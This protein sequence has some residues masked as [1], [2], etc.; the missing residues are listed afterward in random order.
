MS[1]QFTWT[2]AL[3]VVAV[4][5]VCLVARPEQEV[6]VRAPGL[7]APHVAPDASTPTGTGL[8]LGR[9]VDAASGRPIPAATVTLASGPTPALGPNQ[10]APPSAMTNGAGYFL[11]RD[12]AK[13]S[14]PITATAQG[15]VGGA[16][17][18]LQPD[19]PS[20]PVTLGNDTRA[21]DVVI[22]MWKHGVISGAVR[23]ERGDPM[24]GV[25]VRVLRRTAGGRLA[26]ALQTQTDDRGTY[27]IANL[28]PGD[29]YVAML[30]NTGSV[31]A[32]LAA[33]MRQPGSQ[34]A[35]DLRR[36]LPPIVGAITFG[37]ESI[38]VGDAMISTLGP[39]G[40][41]N[42]APHVGPEGRLTGFRST[43]H[44]AAATFAEAEVVRIGSGEERS[45]VDINVRLTPML[46]IS[47]T[48]VGPDG[49]AANIGVMLMA[50]ALDSVAT[51]PGLETSVTVTGADGRFT[52][53]GVGPGQ[54]RLKAVRVPRP[55][56]P[57]MSNTTIINVGPGAMIGFGGGPPEPPPVSELPTLWADIPITVGE[58]DLTG[59]TLTL[60]TGS[61]IHGQV[62]FEGGA[63][64]S[65]AEMPRIG[66][67]LLLADDRV[68][69]LPPPA[70]VNQS[71]RQ[72]MTAQYPAGRY[73]VT[74]ISLPT[75]WSVRSAMADGV[76]VFERP[77]TLSGQDVNGIVIALTKQP[78]TL[79]GQVRRGTAA[80]DP[81]AIVA[82]FPAD[83]RSW[84]DDGMS[85]RRFRSGT[86]QPDGTFELSG[87]GAGEYIV[88]A[89]SADQPIDGRN[90][91]TI[92]ALARV[93]TR[94][95]I[96]DGASQ[97]PPLTVTT[98]R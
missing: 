27:R 31:P 53:L 38:R 41:R 84:I 30:T 75:G 60:A 74:V 15:Y 52:L 86:A 44:P 36:D 90:A 18:R 61:R 71:T 23:D 49:P 45:D 80:G 26:N 98:I 21:T 10:Q 66:I 77:L 65:A 25:G 64:P 17:G 89:V 3:G 87:L 79:T 93:G 47:G 35:N 57:S 76:N 97:A 81:Q 51:L 78:N 20:R 72:F 37:G 70:P 29:Y 7:A 40:N 67:G 42:L 63:L 33:V 83:Y 6:V 59:V 9:V 48:V 1:S 19:G 2:L 73:V 46:A 56:Q 24:V 34:A 96:R 28:A 92:D 43:Y 88:A 8:I 22:R 50:G 54:Y 94:V 39:T 68:E 55:P 95:T 32:P 11:F 14:Y 12:L 69:Q 91:E 13:G 58:R 82:A 4:A 62:V 5:S 16:N 85:S